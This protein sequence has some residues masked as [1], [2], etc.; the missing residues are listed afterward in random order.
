MSFIHLGE[1][2]T[3]RSVLEARQY[4][5]MTKNKKERMHA[6]TSSIIHYLEPRI[7]ETIHIIDP[8]LITKLED[9]MK[10]W[11]YLMT[12]YNLKPG[13]QKFSA[14]GATAAIDKLTQLH[15]MDTWTAINLSKLT[16][17]DQM[18]VLSLLLFLKEKQTR[19]FK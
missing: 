9:K 17:E 18:K 16:R 15:M 11:G 8:E 3:H 19:K 5:G 2:Q 10:I 14:K 4:T 6:T 12:Q 13:L 7:D 1:V